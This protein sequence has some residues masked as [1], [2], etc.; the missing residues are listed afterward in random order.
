MMIGKN[1]PGITWRAALVL[2]AAWMGLANHAGADDWDRVWIGG[3]SGAHI[4]MDVDSDGWVDSISASRWYKNPKDGS[5]DWAS[6][7]IGTSGYTPGARLKVGDVNGDGLPDI[8]SGLGRSYPAPKRNEIH[9]FINPGDTGTWDRYHIG[10]LSPDTDD[11]VETVAIGDMNNDGFPDILA[12]GECKKLMW[13]V[14]PG[15]PMESNW[16]E[17]YTLG[18]NFDHHWFDGYAD[19]EGMVIGHF[20]GDNYPDVAITTCSPNGLCGGTFVLTNPKTDTGNWARTEL[21]SSKYACMETIAK[22]DIGTDGVD[23]VV[24]VNRNHANPHLYWYDSADSWARHDIDTLNSS[25]LTGTAPE[26][27]DIDGDGD[28]DIICSRPSDTTTYW[29]EN[30]GTD[31]WEKHRIYGEEL[32]HKLYAVGDVDKNGYPDIISNG[33]LYINPIPEPSTIALL[34]S[35]I[36]CLAA[37][38]VRRKL[39]CRA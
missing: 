36:V 19:V 8:V 26:V 5:E 20:D 13:Y 6:Y 35:G 18:E 34:L 23:D 37:L 11:G 9:A 12:G 14:N 30:D 33:W 17:S 29:Y 10:T 38:A 1:L 4:L 3:G 22:G 39:K 21:D 7:P 27:A 25:T 32:Y 16:T 2:V 31:T 24:F 28:M 15:T